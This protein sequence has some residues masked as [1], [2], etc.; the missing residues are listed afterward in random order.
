MILTEGNSTK[1][2]TNICRHPHSCGH[3]SVMKLFMAVH[4]HMQ[5]ERESETERRGCRKEGKEMQEWRK[6]RYGGT[7]PV[8][9]CFSVCRQTAFPCNSFFF[10]FCI[11]PPIV[12][13]HILG[14]H[15]GVVNYPVLGIYTDSTM[16]LL[17]QCC[18]NE[19]ANSLFFGNNIKKKYLFH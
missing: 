2:Q 5:R 11:F 12:I 7:L 3:A 9:I 8:G 19:Y 1:N 18:N 10:F 4:E 15:T 14:Q 13:R 6:A 17:L 16:R